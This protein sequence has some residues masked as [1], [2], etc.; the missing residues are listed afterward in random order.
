MA[1]GRIADAMPID[2]CKARWL[3]AA[4]NMAGNCA[5]KTASEV[6]EAALRKVRSYNVDIDAGRINYR[7]KDH[8][9]IIDAALAPEQDK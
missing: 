9:Q 5:W 7:P 4:W 2:Y 1:A 3:I 6:L 8:I